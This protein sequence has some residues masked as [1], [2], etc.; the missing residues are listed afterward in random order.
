MKC[1]ENGYLTVD[2][3]PC[4]QNLHPGK[5]SCLWHGKSDAERSDL[6]RRGAMRAGLRRALPEN[7][8]VQEFEHE[9]SVIAFAREMAQKV[10]TTNVDP[11][12]IDVGLRAASV[13]L[14]GFGAKTQRR[15][16]DAIAA[17]EHGGAAMVLLAKLTEG[18][19]SG[20]RQPITPRVLSA[21]REGAQAS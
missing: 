4:G 5:P 2:G 10:L 19:G 12:R 9:D 18:V 21:H 3:K 13:A 1:G 8:E 6:A 20:K 15:L 11:R 7:Y 17:L 16:V 14:A